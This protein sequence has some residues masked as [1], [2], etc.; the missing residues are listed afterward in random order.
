MDKPRSMAVMGAALFAAAL[1]TPF[2]IASRHA[3]YEKTTPAIHTPASPQSE[4]R[5][6]F[7]ESVFQKSLIFAPPP[8]WKAALENSV[9]SQNDSQALTVTVTGKPGQTVTISAICD[10]DGLT[11][12]PNAPQKIT[13]PTDATTPTAAA[14]W[15][16][17]PKKLGRY[18][19]NLNDGTKN[20]LLH[21]T[22]T[23]PLGLT[24]GLMEVIAAVVKF[25]GGTLTLP[26][27][28][29][30]IAAAMMAARQ[31]LNGGVLKPNGGG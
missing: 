22:V 6:S 29:Q 23:D 3:S 1:V 8:V 2:A 16:A 20:T 28:T 5:D 10:N 17:Q 27:L 14:V 7:T 24:P 4:R 18:A 13:L 12:T 19:I 21:V 11:L 30:Q 15:I 9:M 26:W 25:L 31:K